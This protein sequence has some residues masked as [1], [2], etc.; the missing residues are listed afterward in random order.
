M[1]SFIHRGAFIEFS[2]SSVAED[3]ALLLFVSVFPRIHSN[4]AHDISVYIELNDRLS[5]S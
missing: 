4:N 2:L 3:G 5:E 1:L